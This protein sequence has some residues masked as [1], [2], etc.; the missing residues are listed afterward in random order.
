MQSSNVTVLEEL[1]SIYGPGEP[2]PGPGEVEPPHPPSLG[3]QLRIA[4]HERLWPITLLFATLA[5]LATVTSALGQLVRDNRFE[6]FAN[7]ARRVA[8]TLSIWDGSRGLGRVRE[9]FWPGT[10]GPLA[11]LRGLGLSTVLSQKLWHALV[12]VIL[13]AGTVAVLRLL[14]PRIGIEHV[15]TGLAVMFGA[16]SVSFLV[17]SNLSF[18]VALAPWMVV[19]LWRGVTEDRPWRWAAVFALV[20][21]LAGNTDVPGLIY[22]MIPLLPVSIYL[23]VVERKVR[24]RDLVG[25]LVR[26]GLLCLLISAASLAKTSISAANFD[27]R[28]AETESPRVS[29]VTS[30][31]SESFRGLGNWLS[32]F[33]QSGAMQKPQ[34]EPYF[35]NP[36]VILATF[37][38]PIVAA[39]VLWRSRWRARRALCLDDRLLARDHG[40]SV[41]VDE[42]VPVGWAPA[43]PHDERGLAPGL[44]EHL[45]V[46]S[47]TGHG[48]GHPVRGRCRGRRPL[49]GPLA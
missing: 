9:D 27:Q 7:P 11:V 47:R 29:S 5:S 15:L 20:V 39:M 22:S 48:R 24:V 2:K 31:W 8:K 42:A 4:A 33:R 10:T 23:V 38:P 28:L 45:Q 43:G 36:L 49:G 21:F 32:Y 25:W 30:S 16:Y 13:G 35:T 3:D 1:L 12:L 41:P 46:R 14:R 18:Q 6:Q 44:P 17:P 37:V 40:R 34:G 19:A 26:A